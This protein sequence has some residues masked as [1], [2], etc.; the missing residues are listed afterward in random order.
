MNITD[1]ADI[2]ALRRTSWALMKELKHSAE[3][4]VQLIEQLEPHLAGK[5]DNP[6]EL[7][8][9]EVNLQVAATTLRLD[10]ESLETI[11]SDITEAVPDDT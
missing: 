3:A 1:K 8:N 6:D 11:L 4:V 7:E 10:A 2:T 5:R 9:L